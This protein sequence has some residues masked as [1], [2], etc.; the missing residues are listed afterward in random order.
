[1]TISTVCHPHSALISEGIQPTFSGLSMAYLNSFIIEHNRQDINC[2][3]LFQEGQVWCYL[4]TFFF[5]EINLAH[6]LR[7]YKSNIYQSFLGFGSNIFP[8]YKFY[9]ISLMIAAIQKSAYLKWCFLRQKAL[10]S[11]QIEVIRHACLMLSETP[12]LKRFDNLFSCLLESYNGHKL[13]KG[14]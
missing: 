3:C 11:V 8:I 14:F 5:K 12:L 13:P 10:K 7:T 2:I 4:M 9:L 1:M 6:F